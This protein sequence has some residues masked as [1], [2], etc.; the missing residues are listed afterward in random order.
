MGGGLCELNLTPSSL[1]LVLRRIF[2]LL[3]ITPR[4]FYYIIKTF[5]P[6]PFSFS[7]SFGFSPL[8]GIYYYYILVI[9]VLWYCRS[10]TQLQERDRA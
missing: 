4:Y 1:C 5:P 2:S 9:V 7:L 3:F 10:V 8:G 6:P